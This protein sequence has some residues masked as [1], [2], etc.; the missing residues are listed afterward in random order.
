MNPWDAKGGF[1][2]I[3]QAD[4]F[5][6]EPEFAKIFGGV[7]LTNISE[8]SLSQAVSERESL[9]VGI[10]IKA[11]IVD[12]DNSWLDYKVSTVLSIGMRLRG[13][14]EEHVPFLIQGVWFRKTPELG[15]LKFNIK[16]ILAKKYINL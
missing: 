9:I 12:V 4:I 15:T 2:I 16:F 14:Q 5:A 10:K 1:S 11:K 7:L 6:L 3:F 8:Y 13:L